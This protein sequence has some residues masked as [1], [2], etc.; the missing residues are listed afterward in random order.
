LFAAILAYIC[1]PIVDK[2]SQ[3]A[4][5]RLRTDLARTVGS[6]LVMLMLMGIFIALLLIVVPLLQKELLLVVQRLPIYLNTVRERLDPWLLQHFGIT[7]QIDTAQIQA[8][9]T[10]NW[11]TATNFLGPLLLSVSSHGL[12]LVG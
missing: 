1:S 10:Q 2:I 7:L 6:I 12:A 5:G 8:I 3:Y 4:L 9:L 11:K